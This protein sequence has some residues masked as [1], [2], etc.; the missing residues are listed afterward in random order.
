MTRKEIFILFEGSSM[1]FL[2]EVA[3][4]LFTYESINE[5]SSFDNSRHVTQPFSFVQN[6]CMIEKTIKP[7]LSYKNKVLVKAIVKCKQ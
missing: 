3:S 4:N 2:Y 7:G 5:D 6:G 1:D